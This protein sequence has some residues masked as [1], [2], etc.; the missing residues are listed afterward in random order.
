[1]DSLSNSLNPNKH[2]KEE[3]VSNLTGSSMLEISALLTAVSILVL[4]R[5]SIS[6]YRPNDSN[7]ADTSSKKSDDAIVVPRNWIAYVATLSVDFLFIVAPTLLLITVLA[8]WTYT[9][10]I[11]VI[12][13]LIF[14]IVAK[15]Y[16]YSPPYLD[17]G[18][19]SLRKTITSYRVSAMIMTY[20]CILAVDFRIFPREYAKTETYG[21][22]LMDLGV[23]FFVLV[24]AIVSRQA[25]NISSVNWKTTFQST[26]PLLLLGL[27]RLVFTTGVDY[28][29]HVG[30]YGV[31]WNFFFTLAAVSI[32]TCIFNVPPQYSGIVGS[33]I[34]IGY[35]SWLIHG[36]NVYLLSNERDT[37]IIS[38]NKEGFFSVFG[39]WGLY[40]VGVQL[41]QYL[42]FG[43]HQSPM[44]RS[45]KWARTRVWIFSLLFWALTLLLDRHV[46]RV[47]R[48]MVGCAALLYLLAVRLLQ[49]LKNVLWNY[50]LKNTYH[51][52]YCKMH[53]LLMSLPR[54]YFICLLLV[55]VLA[56]L[57][58]SD[59]VPGSETTALEEAFN[60]NLLASFL[61]ANMLTG[62]VNFL[63]DTLSASWMSA[64]LILFAY[65]F[66]LS[67]TIGFVDFY[68]IRLKFW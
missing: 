24:N 41:G 27:G 28:Q 2:L 13:L 45:N 12:L 29:L 26:C 33:I 39:Y 21:T 55:Q 30:E 60:R 19:H 56:I 44:S 42:F 63:V 64:L 5:H 1:M 7:K 37:D 57:M 9:C 22:G 20:L 36:L 48:R 54:T 35:Q 52:F 6:S 38:K 61:L 11:L 16:G 51:A 59:Y 3:F 34:L 46:D 25:R 50:R 58:L 8:E 10:A 43:N 66:I 49:H 23:G 47:S 68:G 15:R 62:L 67:A 31:H 32:L 18:P 53:M 14:S 4:L 65:A 17:R 40:L